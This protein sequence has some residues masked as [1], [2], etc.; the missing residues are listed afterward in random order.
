[1]E[2]MS[3]SRIRNLNPPFQLYS[4]C[5]RQANTCWMAHSTVGWLAMHVTRYVMICELTT[6]HLVFWDLALRPICTLLRLGLL[7]VTSGT[8]GFLQL[9][10]N[11]LQHA[12]VQTIYLLQ[13]TISEITFNGNC[14]NDISCFEAGARIIFKFQK[15]NTKTWWLYIVL[16]AIYNVFFLFCFFK[17]LKKIKSPYALDSEANWCNMTFT[18]GNLFLSHECHLTQFTTRILTQAI[19]RSRWSSP[20]LHHV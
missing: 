13:F 8:C 1:M 5:H 9:S 16:C 6:C 17:H 10:L 11:L 14:L 15:A 2:E 12:I 20:C 3:G 18:V 7:H 19:M 4:I